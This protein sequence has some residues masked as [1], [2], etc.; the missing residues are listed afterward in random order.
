MNWLLGK[1]GYSLIDVWSLV[2][3]CFWVF[4]GSCFWARRAQVLV[5][6]G[7]CLGVAVGWEVFER[8]AEKKW[9][10]TWLN[11]ESWWNSWVSDL[12]TVLLG[13]L[14]IWT[15]LNRFGKKTS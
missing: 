14:M 4:V 6:L 13:V 7:I 2:H 12:S 10:D 1:T 5:S 15:L 8:F 9:P 11:P 3:F